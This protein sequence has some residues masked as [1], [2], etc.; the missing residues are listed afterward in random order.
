[1]LGALDGG[2]DQIEIVERALGGELV[3]E[4]GWPSMTSHASA[5][6]I[7]SFGEDPSGTLLTASA[8]RL[9]ERASAVKQQ[10]KQVCV[11][12]EARRDDQPLAFSVQLGGKKT[13]WTFGWQQGRFKLLHDSSTTKLGAL[14][15]LERLG[16]VQPA[17]KKWKPSL[18]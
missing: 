13:D 9:I 17:K 5:D 2:E 7:E 18:K 1:L 12:L 4:A 3:A 11:P 14:Q 16:A 6:E 8:R 15:I 10:P